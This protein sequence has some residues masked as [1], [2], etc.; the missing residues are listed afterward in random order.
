MLGQLKEPLTE[1][2][3]YGK[4]E[5][6]MDS[7]AARYAGADPFP[8]IV[9]DDFLNPEVLDRVLQEFPGLN[10]DQ[11]IHYVHV[12]ERK[13]GRTKRETFSQITGA[14]VD[15]LN[16]PR[17]V[18]FLMRLTGIKNLFADFSFEGGGLHQSP[19]GGYLNIHADFTVH[20]HHRNWQ[21]RV[22]VL[23]YLNKDWP[24]AYGGHLELWDRQMARCVHKVAPLFNRAVI[25]NTDA[26]S[27][28]GHPEPLQCPEGM[29]RKSIALYYFTEEASPLVRSTEYRGR[30]QDG[31]KKVGIFADKMALRLYDRVKRL[32]GIND[33]WVSRTLRSI[34]TFKRRFR[35]RS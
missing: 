7:L 30:P 27:F 31:L 14:V 20:P 10:D 17:F 19:R 21:R 26:D 29:S 22:N 33:E 8:H 28:H 9:L 5:P 4:W 1:I 23:V 34:D 12:N 16:S 35:G 32:T 18:A 2:F 25:F 11:W 15:E 24:D 13:Y 3:P 6:R